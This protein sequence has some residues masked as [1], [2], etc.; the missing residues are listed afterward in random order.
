LTNI[1]KSR[2]NIERP[3]GTAGQGG[4]LYFRDNNIMPKNP[5]NRINDRRYFYDFL[6]LTRTATYPTKVKKI[7][8]TNWKK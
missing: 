4:D 2:T 7:P 5:Q 3:S 1:G 8:Y 6:I